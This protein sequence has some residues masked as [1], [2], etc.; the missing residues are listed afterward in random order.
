V[1]S[2]AAG[3]LVKYPMDLTNIAVRDVLGNP[4]VHDI[5]GALR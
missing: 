3:L 5:M 1:L 2:L 4:A